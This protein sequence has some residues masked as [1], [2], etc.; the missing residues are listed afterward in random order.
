MIYKTSSHSLLLTVSLLVISLSSSC[1]SNND[2]ED[3]PHT[4]INT[5]GMTIHTALVWGNE[6]LD[7][8][9][10][11]MYTDDQR[12]V[13]IFSPQLYISEVRFIDAN[14]DT[15]HENDVL[16]I[17]AEN[18]SI[19]LKDV[20]KGSYEQII[21]TLGLPLHINKAVRPIDFELDHPLGPKSPNMW[22][23]WDDGYIFA[24]IEGRTNQQTP[25]LDTLADNFSWHLGFS[26][27]AIENIALDLPAHDNWTLAFDIKHLF[28]KVRV[29][30][31]LFTMNV[32]RA[33]IDNNVANIMSE[34]FVIK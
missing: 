2:D 7:V 3:G 32:R 8:I 11:T 14:G 13:K 28:S 9:S 16:F 29:P 18:N 30:D 20:P 24:R 15:I 34:S 27:N 10:N 26:E 1:K 22:W 23:N 12:P 6:T 17:S 25:P 31:E 33:I 21:F 5:S 4:P 19:K